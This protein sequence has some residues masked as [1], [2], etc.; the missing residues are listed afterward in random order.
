MFRQCFISNDNSHSLATFCKAA[1]YYMPSIRRSKVPDSLW[2]QFIFEMAEEF[3]Q[4]PNHPTMTMV[5]CIG[6]QPQ[7][8]VWVFNSEIQINAM[9]EL[10]PKE[11]Q[12]YFWLVCTRVKIN[13]S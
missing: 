6:R 13:T 3:C 12:E 1:S 11:D 4:E 2:A 5:T 7:S 10:I 8:S 9:G